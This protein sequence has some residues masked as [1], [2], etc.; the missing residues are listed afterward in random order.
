MVIL[1]LIWNGYVHFF[2][3]LGSYRCVNNNC[4]DGFVAERGGRC[5][6]VDECAKGEHHC[7]GKICVKGC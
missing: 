1:Q 7:P 2:T 5:I 3:L 4:P 6:D